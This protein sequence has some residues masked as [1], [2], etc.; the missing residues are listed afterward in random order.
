MKQVPTGLKYV[1]QLGRKRLII[2]LQNQ[3]GEFSSSC[4]T[5]GS[6]VPQATILEPL[7]FIMYIHDLPY[8]IKSYTKPVIY[9]DDTTMLIIANTLNDLQTQ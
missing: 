2:S 8:G 6:C 5:T 3:K 7:L 4:E 1:L 9:S